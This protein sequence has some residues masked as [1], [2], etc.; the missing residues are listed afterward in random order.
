MPAGL[1][2]S[3]IKRH[4][5]NMKLAWAEYRAHQAG[6]GT[7]HAPRRRS[8]AV[9]EVTEQ[10]SSGLRASVQFQTEKR[11]DPE[12][13]GQLLLG[14]VTEGIS[15]TTG[16]LSL[17]FPPGAIGEP[18]VS[19]VESREWFKGSDEREIG[20]EMARALGFALVRLN[21]SPQQWASIY[22][23]AMQAISAQ[24]G[25][26]GGV[27]GMGGLLSPL[28]GPTAVTSPFGALRASRLHRGV[29]LS[30]AVG[31]EVRAPYS[32]RVQDVFEEAEGGKSVRLALQRPDGGYAADVS[33][34]D[35]SGLLVT[36]SHLSEQ[37]VQ[38]GDVVSA[39]QVIARTGNTGTE[40]TGPHLHIQTEYFADAPFFSLDAN[41]RYFVDPAG[42]W[43]GT[44]ELV[45]T[46]PP[47]LPPASSA[48]AGIAQD[49]NTGNQIPFV[50]NVTSG[51]TMQVV[52]Q[53][54]AV[55]TNA[56]VLFP[57]S[58]SGDT[59]YQD[60]APLPDAL[61]AEARAMGADTLLTGLGTL[62][63]TVIG[64]VQT[65][66]GPVARVL[67]QTVAFVGQAVS[68]LDQALGFAAPIVGTAL[69]AAGAGL[70]VATPFLAALGPPGE[71]IAGATGIAGP[72]VGGAG[73]LVGLFGQPIAQAHGQV[74][75][76]ATAAFQQIFGA[77]PTTPQQ[78]TAVV[79]AP[80]SNVYGPQP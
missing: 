27:P 17:Y 58:G 44:E 79:P 29:D 3:Y 38:K 26:R 43:G 40:T 37:L 48:I 11:V 61:R 70:T 78:Q 73:T 57:L 7:T 63:G 53:G 25:A 55:N 28:P 75:Q 67:G 20:R 8:S 5:G 50:V 76:G 77:F 51:G 12:A 16:E 9:H 52:G 46:D 30:A 49:R 15:P 19:D 66:T 74:A 22:P 72:V 14:F 54:A 31:T 60:N 6:G 42:V 33:A 35:D 10:K 69:T 80:V 47:Q 32:A 65:L 1:P 4:N 56:R 13:I 68:A 41:A 36:F 2:A 24:G 23:R 62:A 64:V 21:V 18:G 45:G 59:G 71:A 34:S 39:G